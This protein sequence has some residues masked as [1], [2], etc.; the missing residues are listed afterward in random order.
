MNAY[1]IAT[2]FEHCKKYLDESSIDLT[3]LPEATVFAVFPD[4]NYLL[5]SVKPPVLHVPC[6]QYNTGLVA[7]FSVQEVFDYI[8]Q[9]AKC[10]C[11]I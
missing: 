3:K 7:E 9:D 6:Y 10:W 4:G 2:S 11:E 8:Q 5:A 1:L